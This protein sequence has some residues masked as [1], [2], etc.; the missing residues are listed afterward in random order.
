M[1]KSKASSVQSTSAGLYAPFR[2]LGLICDEVKFTTNLKGGVGYIICS[3]G[4]TFHIYSLEK[5]ELV[6]V[7]PVFDS[8]IT[9][10]AAFNDFTI[11]A[12]GS[13][14]RVVERNVEVAKI[15]LQQ[16]SIHSMAVLGEFLVAA[17]E[18]SIYVFYV[19]N[20]GKKYLNLRCISFD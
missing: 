6:F 13:I 3:I 17:G 14:I 7:G 16:D 9:A 2:D 5:L 4:H 8:K 20:Y 12:T 11:V 1:K 18:S 10:L 19:G 15:D